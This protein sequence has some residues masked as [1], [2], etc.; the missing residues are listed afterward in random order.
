MKN[1]RYE[2]QT[3]QPYV[4][5]VCGGWIIMGAGIILMII[6]AVYNSLNEFSMIAIGFGVL[7][8]GISLFLHAY[9]QKQCSEIKE[10]LEKILTKSK[11][12]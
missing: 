9:T 1:E 4:V 7:A 10:Q 8:I 2:K 5:G 3:E 11:L 6:A 12:R